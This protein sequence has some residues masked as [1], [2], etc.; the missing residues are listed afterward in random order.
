[1]S[2]H[3]LV[4]DQGTTSTRTIVFDARLEPKATAQQEFRQIFPQPGWVEHD[5]EEIWATAR[6]TIRDAVSKTDGRIVA[7]GLANQRE[8]ALVWDRKTL[9]PIYNAIVW[10]DRRTAPACQRLREAGASAM[11]AQR[12]GLVLDPYFSAAKIAWI[13]DNVD[14]ARARAQ[15]GELAFGTVD[16]FLIARMTGGARH[17][18]DATNASRT[19]LFNIAEGA[20]DED[21]LQLF[22][23]PRA[24]LP[25]ALDCAAD[26][27]LATTE[28]IGLDAPILGVAGD[29]QAALIGQACF[30]PGMVK[31]TYGTGA[32]LL[33]NTGATRVASSKT[34]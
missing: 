12:T 27:G 7:I 10:Q 31:S 25:E 9:Q 8:T 3:I 30:A 6:A 4:L 21:L 24:L 33:L 23:V 22:D 13:L 20:W 28:A 34:C 1:M 15:R 5:P 16:T 14:G 29:Q 18:T 17:V 2:D 19:S 11:V 26:F 32:F